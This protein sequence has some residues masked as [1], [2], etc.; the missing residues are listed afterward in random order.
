MSDNLK[1][2][3]TA[4]IHLGRPVKH[5]GNPPKRVEEHFNQAGLK[6]CRLMA[7][8]A[9]AEQVDFLLISGDLYDRRARSVKASRFLRDL[10]AELKREGIAVYIISGN[11]D[12]G[13]AENEPFELPD[14]AKILAQDGVEMIRHPEFLER[15]KP[16][17]AELPSKEKNSRARV[18]GQSYRSRF[19][20][21]SMYRYFTV[22]DQ[23]RYNIGMLHTQLTADSSR[24]V[25]VSKS[26]LRD[27][28]GIH[29]W[30]LGHLHRPQVL[31]HK[32]PAVVFPGTPQAHSIGERGLKG[33]FLV[34]NDPEYPSR[35]PSINFI[36]TSPVIFQRLVVDIS[37]EAEKGG[38]TIE[39]LTDLKERL[40]KRARKFMAR[41]N[42]DRM[43]FPGSS[44]VNL[45]EPESSWFS[46]K[47]IKP[48]RAF[49]VRWVVEGRG[50][51]HRYIKDNFAEAAAELIDELNRIFA[52]AGRKT[53]L[54]S[55]SLQFHTGP[56]LPP[57]NELRENELYDRVE[58]ILAELEE[59][60]ELKK[61]LLSEWGEIWQGSEEPEERRDDRFYPDEETRRE[62][63]SAARREIITLLFDGD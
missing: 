21:R 37:K 24:Y 57:H 14:N 45:L 39:T 36:P 17:E 19:E 28:S 29:Y 11:H 25:P 8:A 63:L 12:P 34:G 7:A 9:V 23:T 18:L 53:I 48:G 16:A 62:I 52:D 55:K 20:E 1:F 2:I 40:K 43:D 44:R 3:H 32:P 46:G 47:K 41:K 42:E 10:F 5:G 22:P 27:K 35:R 58:K 60:E 4:D 51:V 26:D 30:A 33:C 38:K 49:I 31:N 59:D 54:W 15:N 6:A 50:P 61:E 13:G 56:E